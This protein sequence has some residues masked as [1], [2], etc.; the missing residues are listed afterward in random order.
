VK[1]PDS[2]HVIKIKVEEIYNLGMGKQKIPAPPFAE[3]GVGD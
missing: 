2:Q 3:M 1:Q